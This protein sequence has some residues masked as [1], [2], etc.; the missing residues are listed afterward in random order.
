MTQSFRRV[1][2][3]FAS[4][5]LT[6]VLLG[7]AMLLIFFGTLAQRTRGIWWVMDQYFTSWGVWVPLE[8]FLPAGRTV[9][10]SFPFPGG[11]AIGL[12][13]FI[14]LIAA[15]S[16]RF[17]FKASG[18]RLVLG[19]LV[20]VVGAAVITWFQSWGV[21]G[22]LKASVG[23]AA[24]LLIGL[25]AYLPALVG[26]Y[27]LFGNRA[28][29]VLIHGSLILLIAGE[30]VTR[31]TA[32]ETQMPIYVGQTQ[33][34]TQDIRVAELAVIHP[35]DPTDP[36][37]D[38][39]A[40]ERVTVFPEEV[41]KQGAVTR[42]PIAHASL[43]FEFRVEQYFINSALG[44][45]QPGIAPPPDSRGIAMRMGLIARPRATGVGQ[46]QMDLPGAWLTLHKQGEPLGRFAVTTYTMLL[47]DVYR[48]IRQD[49]VID[50]QTW[51]IDMR[52]KRYYRPYGF[53][54]EAFSHDL[55]PGTQV[56]KNFASDIRIIEP[57]DAAPRAVNIRM[58]HPLRYGG[59]TFFQSGYIPDPSGGADLGTV[60]Q[61]VR[62]PGSTMPYIACALGGVGLLLHFCVSLWK[63]VGRGVRRGGAK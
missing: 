50:G 36:A 56:P 60:L 17:R 30:A 33:R 32:L 58:N 48:T 28:G 37:D 55:Y 6:V 43:P 5:R 20:F 40:T 51:Q 12:A 23:V 59:D 62:N 46:A 13:V 41:L 61:V 34:W 42:Q 53:H 25:V 11:A 22:P 7:L 47:G 45:Y 14:N 49:V 24:M 31:T 26:T 39:Q 8:I 18:W 63:Y 4:L 1:I 27:L 54:L 44:P 9:D 2:A 3:P 29:I 15:H 38:A 16:V 35:P 10:G 19:L 21:I 57:G 52:F